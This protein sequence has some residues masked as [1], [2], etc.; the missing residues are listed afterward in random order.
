[1]ARNMK[2][3]NGYGFDAST[4]EGKTLEEIKNEAGSVKTVAGVSPDASGNVPLTAASVGARPDTWAPTP[5][6]IGAVPTTRKINNTPLTGDLILTSENVGAIPKVAGA[7]EGAIPT[8]DAGGTLASSGV[9]MAS[10]DRCT[11]S[12][13]GG[14]LTIT[15]VS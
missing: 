5:A 15:T 10:F 7:A 14:V 8:F 12:L 4:L 11:F 13:S 6:E 1:M 9:T 2:T 3:L